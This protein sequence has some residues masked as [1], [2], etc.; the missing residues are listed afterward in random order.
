MLYCVN[1]WPVISSV[2]TLSCIISRLIRLLFMNLMGP[3]K[4]AVVCCIP[5]VSSLSLDFWSMRPLR[6]FLH[7]DIRYAL[8]A[9][10]YTS[11]YLGSRSDLRSRQTLQHKLPLSTSKPRNSRF[12]N[13]IWIRPAWVHWVLSGYNCRKY[14]SLLYIPVIQFLNVN[15]RGPDGI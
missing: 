2:A 9:N 3:W 4:R 13:W 6:K 12:P 10:L 5:F 8:L 15:C 7:A 14:M 1:Q 11:H